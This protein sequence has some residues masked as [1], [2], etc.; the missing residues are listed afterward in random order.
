MRLLVDLKKLRIAP[1]ERQINGLKAIL[2]QHLEWNQVFNLSAHRTEKNVWIYQILDSLT[3]HKF[4]KDGHLLDIGTGPGFPGLPLALMYPNTHVTLLDSNE[5]KLAFAR[6]IQSICEL[7]NVTIVQKRIEQYQ[8]DTKFDQIISRAFTRLNGII[9]CSLRLLSKDGEILAMKGAQ[10]D[11]EI[12]EAEAE[13]ERCSMTS[14][15]LPHVVDEQR[16]LVLVKQ[17][18]IE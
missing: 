18:K 14:H 7:D 15:K 1:D 5:K 16:M 3:P 10:I 11:N 2:K 9:R 17:R 13:F 12:L 6:N 8:I 4:I